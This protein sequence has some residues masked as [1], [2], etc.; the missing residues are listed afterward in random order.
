ME[1]NEVKLPEEE[2]SLDEAAKLDALENKYF[3]PKTNIKYRMTFKGWKLVQKTREKYDF[4][5]KKTIPGEYVKQVVLIL[6]LD[7]LDGV[8]VKSDGSPLE[9]T[10]DINSRSCRAAWEPYLRNNQIDKMTFEF[11]QEGENYDRK[12]KVI[13]AG[14]RPGQTAL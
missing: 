11:L 7:S 5:A 12:Y 2:V 6:T 8:S 3:K 14:M 4:V 1:A 9:M 13:V 10:W